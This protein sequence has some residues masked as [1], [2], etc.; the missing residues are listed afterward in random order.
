[1]I[2][3]TYD[4]RIFAACG[5]YM[6]TTGSTTRVWSL[7]TGKLILS[8]NHGEG[9]KVTAVCFKPSRKIEDEG[10]TLW[11][12]TN[13]GAILELD[14]NLKKV[15]ASNDVSHHRHEICGMWRREPEIW[16][17]DSEGKFFVWPAASNGAPSLQ[18]GVANTKTGRRPTASVVIGDQLWLAF[19]KE[20]RVLR[21]SQ[22]FDD[23]SVELMHGLLSIQDLG[24]MTAATILN[25][26]GK[27]VY[28]GHSDGKISVFSSDYTC[29]AVYNVGSHKISSLVGVGA[30]LW[31]GYSNG[32]I[33]VY[34][35]STTPWTVQKD[36][37][38]HSNPVLDMI[39]DHSSIW[40]LNR[41]QVLSLGGENIAGVWDG[42]L[43][44]DWL[45]NSG[46]FFQIRR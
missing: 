34:D 20:I 17:L 26:G 15:V 41:L 39:L 9:V 30:D 6:C 45:G 22:T 23:D 32:M 46:V 8:M 2:S 33:Y 16:T 37:R 43:E 25:K 4:T 28:F 18:N 38:A 7:L 27:Q 40:K 13:W 10:T 1:M 11:L 19:G 36:W 31:A 3:N 14:I 24:D 12:G 29:Q 21:P 35:I 44:E 5:E 42:M